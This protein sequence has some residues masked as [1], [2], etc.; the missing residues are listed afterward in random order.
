MLEKL[1][2]ASVRIRVYFIGLDVKKSKSKIEKI[3]Q[4]QPSTTRHQHPAFNHHH[5]ITIFSF[6]PPHLQ[7]LLSTP[8]YLPSNIVRLAMVNNS[9]DGQQGYCICFDDVKKA[10]TR[11]QGIAHRTPVLTSSSISSLAQRQLFFKVE[12]LQ[13]T[14]S[15]KFRGALNAV[16]DELEQRSN[17]NTTFLP[18]V[19]HSSGNHAQA[20]ALAAQLS[21]QSSCKVQATI[22]MPNDCPDVKKNAVE[23]FGADVVLVEP[24]NEARK[25]KAEEIQMATGAIFI[26]PSEDPRVIAGQGT[27][28]LEM[29]EQMKKEYSMNLLDAIIIP[30][31]GGGLASGNIIT[32]RSLLGDKVKVR[33][34][35]LCIHSDVVQI[36]RKIYALSLVVSFV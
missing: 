20:L 19:T 33:F 16:K 9:L 32:L 15:F 31:G 12:A 13:K 10:A 25:Q 36:Y 17:K 29:L 7:L 23:G 14:G 5:P 21:S 1:M 18:V 34:R 27:V 30:V 2:R 35:E 11:I 26:H 3:H 4:H 6:L 28:C 22:V 24:T 8:D